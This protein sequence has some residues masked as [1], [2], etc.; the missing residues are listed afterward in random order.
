LALAACGSDGTG[1]SGGPP[2]EDPTPLPLEVGEHRLVDALQESSC[3]SLEGGAAEREYLLVPYAGRGDQTGAGVSTGFQLR[4]ALETPPA[5]TA[6]AAGP[7]RRGSLGGAAAFHA[8]LRRAEAALARSPVAA[9]SRAQPPALRGAPPTVG[10]VEEF[11]VCRNNTCTSTVAVAATA[12]FVGTHGVIYLDNEMPEG[13]QA[14]TEADITHLGTLFDEYLHP[15]DTAAFGANSDIDGDQRVAIVITDQ[16]NDLSPDCSDGRI[17]GYFFGGDLLLAHPGSNQREVFFAFAPKPPAG[18]CPAVT[19]LTALRSLPP[20]L[21][22]EL[23]HMISFNQRVLLRGRA[24]EDTWLN[25]GLSHYAEEL[26]H[27]LIPDAMCPASASCFG[28]FA[29]GNLQNAYLY[30]EEPGDEFLVSPGDGP[31]L[32]GRGSAWLFVRWLADHFATDQPLGRQLTRGLL[33]GAGNGAANVSS[34]TGQPFARLAGEWLLANHLEGLPG[35]APRG[36]LHYSSWDLRATYAANHPAT[37]ARPYPLIPD[38]T[39]GHSV[40]TGTLR[41]GSGHYL[42]VKVPG[43]EDGVTVR[44]ADA[45]GSLRVS[46]VVDP[47][48]AVVRIR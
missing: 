18:S 37:F 1:P 2:C 38:S 23:Q 30:L 7:S 6:M 25:E 41:G 3:F 34:V 45:S 47:R 14:L 24:D 19:R 17:V 27:R 12:R 42:R 20:V 31:T 48:I 28:Q 9:L 5:L 33:T 10:Q 43:G 16:V 13:A 36:R 32:A 46:G 22:H 39:S 8:G 11:R 4:T 29:T 21:I 15:I 44:I 35:F 40:R 26:G